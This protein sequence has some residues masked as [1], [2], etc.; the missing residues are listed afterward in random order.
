[1]KKLQRLICMLTCC[2][3]AATSLASSAVAA[4]IDSSVTETEDSRVGGTGIGYR[5]VSLG[6]TKVASDLFLSWHPAY[7]SYQ[8]NVS[9]YLFAETSSTLSVSLSIGGKYVSVSVGYSPKGTTTGTIVAADP[10]KASRPAIYGDV[11][12]ESYWAGNYNFN[13]NVWVTK[14]TKERYKSP[15]EFTYIKILYNE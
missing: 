3:L 9:A 2:C 6:E 8:K 11:Y 7:S 14:T 15:R 10:S 12:R 5:E 1:M 13:T 4:N